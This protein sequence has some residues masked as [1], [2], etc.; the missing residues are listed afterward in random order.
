MKTKLERGIESISRFERKWKIKA[1]EDQFK[2]I[3]IVQFKTEQI[4]VNEKTFSTGKEGKFLGLKL[5]NNRTK[6]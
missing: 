2:I 3:P 1:N 5:Q 6:L 4:S